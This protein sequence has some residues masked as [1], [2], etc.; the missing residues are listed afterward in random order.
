ML[1]MA[2]S[3]MLGLGCIHWIRLLDRYEREPYH[4]MVLATLVGG[5]WASAMT[6][7]LYATVEHLGFYNFQSAVGALLVIGPVEE[8]AKLTGLAAV[9][10]IIRKDLNEPADGIIYIACV[11]LGFSLIENFIYAS[12]PS[13][14]HLIFLRLL[15]GTPLHICFSALM[16]LSFYLW[17][18]N[19]KAFHLIITAFVLA[20]LSHGLYD[21]IVF[22]HYSAILLGATFIIMYGFTRNLFIY[23]LAV[24]PHR[25]SLAQTMETFNEADT[26]SGLACLHCG[27]LDAKRHTIAKTHL[28]H[29]SRC[30][31]YTVTRKDLFRLFY[32]YAGIL[33]QTANQHLK[34]SDRGNDFVTLYQGNH[35]CPKRKQAF[36][37]LTELD[38]VL[39][40]L[41]YKVKTKMKSK[42]Y[43]PNNLFRLEQPGVAIDYSK[44]ARDGKTMLWRLLT[45][46]FAKGRPRTYRPPENG[47]L[48]NWIA[49]LI[50]E[51]W[52]AVHGLWGVVIL[53]AGIYFLTAYAAMISNLSLPLAMGIV[54]LAIRPALGR[55]GNRIYYRRHGNWPGE[56][57]QKQQF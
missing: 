26:M 5:G 43:L 3:F 42:W 40:N 20:G 55:W 4:K 50:P 49:F 24:S 16:G 1:L 10:I 52:Y 53:M 29:C 57:T 8:M 30:D 23:A 11:A 28:W 32:H 2:I 47:P 41:N 38:V 39:E 37:R 48:W 12:H 17:L 44:M 25:I 14:E 7:F 33:K 31:H 27:N 51:L 6:W 22:N 34:P 45:L 56:T 15:V 18:K 19:R 54:A 35:I 13:Q 21:L 46:P 9:Y 36:F